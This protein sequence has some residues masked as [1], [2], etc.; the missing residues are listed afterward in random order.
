MPN[1][2]TELYYHLV[3]SVKLRQPQ[4]TFELEAELYPF[5]RWKCRE[6]GVLVHALDG[7]EDHVP[8][9]WQEGYRALT[10]ARTDLSRVVAYIRSQKRHHAEGRLSPV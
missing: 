2:F 5:I 10:F 3:W 4:I 9:Y 1:T 8:F 6:C 7:V